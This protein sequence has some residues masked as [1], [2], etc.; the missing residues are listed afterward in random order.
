MAMIRLTRNRSRGFTLVEALTTAT[1][2]GILSVGVSALYVAS[3]RMY[4]RG[5]REA[6]SRDKASLALERMMPEL[7]EAYNVDYPG[8]SLIVFTMPQKGIDGR[9][10]LD[11]TTK[12]LLTGKQVTFYQAGASGAMGTTGHYIWRAERASGTS[13]W[14][15]RTLV[16]DDVE[17]LS[18]TYAPSIDML[19]LVQAA[20][21][22]G[23]GEHPGY[24]NRTEVAEVWIRNH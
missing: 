11:P 6:T 3:L 5:Q 20:I 12:T 2:L 23:Q 10:A 1:V 22:V 15:K 24:F 9:Y 17:D 4:T 8:P 14:T 19:E 21:T 7:R 13:T 16:M 18:F